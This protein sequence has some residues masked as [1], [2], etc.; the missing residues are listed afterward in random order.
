MYVIQIHAIMVLVKNL[1]MASTLA[2]VRRAMPD[3]IVISMCRNVP[4]HH[5]STAVSVSSRQLAHFDVAVRTAIQVINVNLRTIN[6]RPLLAYTMA[7]ASAVRMDISAHVRLVLR[8]N[9]VKLTL[10]NVHPIHARTKASVCN[11]HC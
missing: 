7:L 6:V 8:A 10:M 9:D 3:S 4:V 11:R 1:P 5:V 2:I